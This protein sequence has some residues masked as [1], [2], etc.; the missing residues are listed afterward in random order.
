MR[1]LM[2]MLAMCL[3]A[4]AAPPLK[5]VPLKVEGD[6]VTIVK[7][8]PCTVTAAPGH[9]VYVWGWPDG[10]KASSVDNVLTITEAPKGEVRITVVAFTIDFTYDEATKKIT[11]KVIRDTGVVVV[12]IGAPAPPGP[13]PPDPT[14]ADLPFKEPGLRVM[15]IED[16]LKRTA[17]PPSQQLIIGSARIREYFKEK[18]AKDAKGLPEACI[19]DPEMDL[20]GVDA[21]WREAMSRKRGPLP[22]IQISNGKEGFE[23]PLPLTVDETLALLKKF[24]G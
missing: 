19:Y 10:V 16:S 5:S 22:W 15:I 3:P 18:C 8:L 9:D 1:A 21:K 4:W 17:L 11:K 2:L 23:G 20:S 13:K 6:T 7:S 12:N 14:P 24:G